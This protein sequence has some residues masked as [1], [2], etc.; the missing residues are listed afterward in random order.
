MNIKS[1]CGYTD[2]R[3]KL[4]QNVLLIVTS[5]KFCMSYDIC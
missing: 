5:L 3:F 2:K 4:I 1:K